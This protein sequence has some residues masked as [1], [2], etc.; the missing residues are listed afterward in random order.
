MR[1]HMLA[2]DEAPGD[3]QIERLVPLCFAQLHWTAHGR[4]AYV[5]MENID[6]AVLR[7]DIVHDLFDLLGSRY[8]TDC[9]ACR[10]AL[11]RDDRDGLLCCIRVEI[12]TDDMRAF[13]RKERRCRLSIA[14]TGTYRAGAEY[15]CD[16][17]FQPTGHKDPGILQLI[18]QSRSG[19]PN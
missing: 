18:R 12:D 7:N 11:T 8:V 10:A 19:T 2:G 4:I 16:L 14:P 13:A 6:P 15:D 1:Q 5:I 3:V 17:V 9:C